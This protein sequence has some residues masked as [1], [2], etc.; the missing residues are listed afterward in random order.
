[1]T[2]KKQDKRG[3]STRALDPQIP[4]LLPRTYTMP[5]FRT[6]T[7]IMDSLE[8]LIYPAIAFKY[9]RIA[10][11]NGEQLECTI[12]SLEGGEAAACAADGMRAINLTM[13]SIL[14]PQRPG[15]I[16]STS[17]LYSDTYRFFTIDLVPRGKEYILLSSPESCADEFK[18]IIIRAT[19]QTRV[20]ALF[21]E[22]PANPT[23]TVWDIK[24]LSRV[25]HE[26]NIPVIVDSTFATPYNCRPLELGADL[27]IQSLT[28]YYC[29][30]GTALGGAVVG[31]RDR[32]KQIKERRQ[33]GG[34]NIDPEAAWLI[35]KG[36][37]TFDRRMERHNKNA[38]LLVRFLHSSVCRSHIAKVYYPG[39]STHPGH[40]A[41]CEQMRTP[42]GKQG[43]SGMVSFELA[44]KESVKPFVEI[45]AKHVAL[46]VSLGSTKSMF[47][48]PALQIHSSLP[49]EERNALGIS[50][51]L[52]RFSVGTEDFKDIKTAFQKA[53]KSLA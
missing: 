30:N 46:A 39:L 3:F 49:I 4:W 50:D 21:I 15:T 28:K 6:S 7:Y 14:H 8:P 12:A 23:L 29:G 44:R 9:P 32:I 37:E 16:V 24:G 51:T 34:G 53:F 25:A 13:D 26:Y 20:E 43:F 40:E 10:H 17:P 45:L 5:I 18:H 2:T 1:M 48:V 41:A 11:P 42:N 35:Q 19:P 52:I 31:S 33:R 36:L 38:A 22:S 27:V 47:S